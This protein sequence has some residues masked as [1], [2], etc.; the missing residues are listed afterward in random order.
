VLAAL[1]IAAVAEE[2]RAPSVLWVAHRRELLEQAATT[3]R[4]GPPPSRRPAAPGPRRERS[5]GVR[6]RDR[7]SARVAFMTG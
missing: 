4:R 1:D 7:R 6:S 5:K 2:G 3:V